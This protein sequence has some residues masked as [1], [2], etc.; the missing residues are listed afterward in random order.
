MDA[1]RNRIARPA[2]TLGARELAQARGGKTARR[3]EQSGR[4]GHRSAPTPSD[5]QDKQSLGDEAYWRLR[6]EIVR[7]ELRPNQALVENSLGRRLGMSR[8][9]IREALRRL[10]A[11]KLIVEG[12]RGLVVYEF[13]IAEIAEIYECR[14]ILE[15]GAA[16]LAA[17]RRTD[18][19]LAAMTRILSGLDRRGQSPRQ[20]MAESNEEFH[21]AI[22]NAAGNP[23][24]REHLERN[25]LFYFSYPL[26]SLY[27][28]REAL[29]SLAQHE[30]MLNTIAEQDPVAA[31]AIARKH[32]EDA[33]ALL[34]S[35]LG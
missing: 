13:T 34:R 2:R 32:I 18:E 5:L 24:L 8:T 4:D 9:P 22:A 26:A 33:L 21:L 16:R 28:D 20:Q 7:G 25:Q 29:E 11:D 6:K 35:K 14:A 10:H 30:A 19:Q 27:S 17:R 1:E 12:I 23:K 15:A 31:E 3:T